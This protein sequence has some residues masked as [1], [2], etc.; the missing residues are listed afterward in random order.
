M[1][2]TLFA[3]PQI[4][5]KFEDELPMTM[6]VG[7]VA[8]DG[9]VLAS[10]SLEY[11]E[12]RV[13][14]FS[15]RSGVEPRITYSASKIRVAEHGKVAVSCA[16]DV[17]ESFD[18]ADAI[19]SRLSRE[20]WASPEPR[21]EE[22]VKTGMEK[23]EWRGAESLIVLSEPSPSLFLLQCLLKDEKTG[24]RRPLCRRVPM[25]AFAGDS[26]NAAV[27]WAVRFYRSIPSESRTIETLKPLAAQIVT[28][29][30]HMSSG[31]IGGLEI[32]YSD[33]SG[34]HALSSSQNQ[35]LEAEA[36][37][38]GSRI[39]EMILSAAMRH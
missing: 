23:Q 17:G 33:R 6:Q 20:F 39:Q 7:M 11:A 14:R 2:T 28:D 13:S 37:L 12:Q 1:S 8:S 21:I 15:S 24:E 25:W 3:A 36:A 16:G 27:F 5:V 38:R 34:I 32:V 19:L 29:G 9:I 18:L 10:D 31:S 22:T 30:G 26:T 4:S 35:A